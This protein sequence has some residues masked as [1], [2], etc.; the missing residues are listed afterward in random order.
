MEFE[1]KKVVVVGGGL[2]GVCQAR[3]LAMKGWEYEKQI[4]KTERGL[5][6]L[7]E[8]VN[9]MSETIQELVLKTGTTER[10]V[11]QLENEIGQEQDSQ[12]EPESQQ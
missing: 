9:K 10:K 3:A 7:R 11:E 1:R 5:K 6:E 2:I 8:I 4:G 12:R